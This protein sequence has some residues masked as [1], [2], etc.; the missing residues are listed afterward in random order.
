VQGLA[1][2]DLPSALLG[3]VLSTAAASGCPPPEL[4]SVCRRFRDALVT[5]FAGAGITLSPACTRLPWDS[6]T[7]QLTRFQVEG[8]PAALPDAEVA[9]LAGV[10]SLS[11]VHI[12][13]CAL[14]VG[15]RSLAA[16]PALHRLDVSSCTLSVAAIEH[17]ARATALRSLDASHCDAIN[18]AA[19]AHIAQIASLTALVLRCCT[20]VT[21]AAVAV[22]AGLPSLCALDLNSCSL[23]DACGEHLVRATSLQQLSLR[24][25]CDLTAAVL[26]PLGGARLLSHLD[27]SFCCLDASALP[28]L[29]AL[30]SLRELHVIGCPNIP[31]AGALAARLPA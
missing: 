22:L 11:S 2:L 9:R 10:T 12:S 30:S 16:L 18:N 19:A 17:L 29:A 23:T 3:R 4:A 24:G 25:C 7:P 21:D 5:S 8:D 31:L 27:F 20:H 14:D 28:R 6:T 15:L 13:G 1:V 26:A